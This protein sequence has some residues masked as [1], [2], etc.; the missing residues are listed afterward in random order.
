MDIPYPINLQ[1]PTEFDLQ[2]AKLATIDQQTAYKGIL[3]RRPSPTRPDAR[4]N[5][6]IARLA[7]KSITGSE[8]TDATIWTALRKP[9]LRT[10]VQQFL[11]KTMHK[12]FVIGDKWSHIPRFQN[13]ALQYAPNAER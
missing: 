12:A 13:R 7:I 9:V 6:E 5:L 11:F 8:G 1:I 3:A 10:R 2:G 4:R